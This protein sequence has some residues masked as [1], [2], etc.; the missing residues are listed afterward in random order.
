MPGLAISGK[1]PPLLLRAITKTL[2]AVALAATLILGV[3][4]A[5]A[6]AFAEGPTATAAG[7]RE[8]AARVERRLLRCTNNHREAHGRRELKLTRALR[9]AARM[10]AKNMVRYQFFSHTDQKG[11]GPAQRVAWFKPAFRVR[12]IGE[13]IAGGQDS[14]R[15]ACRAFMSS[16][17]HRDV[18]LGHWNR[19]GL[20]FWS[21]SGMGRVYVQ[22][23]ALGG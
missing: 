3:C 4:T 12:A 20:G 11:W 6:P 13:N 8:R 16:G 23:F 14:A 7:M 10:H 5:T 9:R 19:V 1:T 21:G 2:A 15:A 18:M 17:D 22:V